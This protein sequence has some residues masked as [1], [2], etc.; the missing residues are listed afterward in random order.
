LHLPDNIGKVSWNNNTQCYN[1]TKVTQANECVVKTKESNYIKLLIN[2]SVLNIKNGTGEYPQMCTCA[3]KSHCINFT[4]NDTS[5]TCSYPPSGQISRWD[6]HNLCLDFSQGCGNAK[7]CISQRTNSCSAPILDSTLHANQPYCEKF[8][9]MLI[10]YKE[11]IKLTA[12]IRKYWVYKSVMLPFDIQLL[13]E[14]ELF[15]IYPSIRV[16]NVYDSKFIFAV[17]QTGYIGDTLRRFIFNPLVTAAQRNIYQNGVFVFSLTG[18]RGGNNSY[19]QYPILFDFV[20]ENFC[21][22]YLNPYDN[23]TYHLSSYKFNVLMSTTESAAR[24]NYNNYKASTTPISV[25]N[26]LSFFWINLINQ[27]EGTRNYS[28]DLNGPIYSP[29]EILSGFA[30]NEE[31]CP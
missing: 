26:K 7:S 23:N 25:A 28:L 21:K 15:N 29:E 13:P 20:K 24:L 2:D 22:A 6:H 31:Q 12:Y 14:A 3:F 19:P 9:K 1:I 10:Y 27:Y 16:N 4:D 5:V 17:F 18:N 8:S 11:E 30:F